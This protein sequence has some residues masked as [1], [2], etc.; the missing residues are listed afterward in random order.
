MQDSG[1]IR[2]IQSV[3]TNVSFVSLQIKPRRTVKSMT[4]SSQSSVRDVRVRS[5]RI[6]F[7]YLLI[8]RTHEF[9]REARECQL[10]HSLMEYHLNTHSN[11]NTNSNTNARTQVRS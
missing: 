11:T 2:K 9:E 3:L 4:S 7:S 6:S 1:L 8:Q 5:A 10:Y